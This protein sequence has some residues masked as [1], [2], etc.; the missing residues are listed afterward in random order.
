MTLNTSDSV[1]TYLHQRATGEPTYLKAHDIA[2]D[3]ETSP[4]TIAQYLHRL[5]D[6]LTDI[7]LTQRNRSETVTWYVQRDTP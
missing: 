1:H 5:Q 6:D 3:L 7:T 2:S 4:I